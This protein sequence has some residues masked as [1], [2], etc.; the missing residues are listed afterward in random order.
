LKPER[1]EAMTNNIHWNK[2][3]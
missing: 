1:L 3:R 2:F